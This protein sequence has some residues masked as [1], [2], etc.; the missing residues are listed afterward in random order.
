MKKKYIYMYLT[1]FLY[2][3]VVDTRDGWM[4][5]IE[6]SE[7]C[8]LKEI[9]VFISQITSKRGAFDLNPE[10]YI[11]IECSKQFKWNLYFCVSGQ[12][13]QFWTVLKLL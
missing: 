12:S 5:M 8:I 10:R 2:I 3:L 13:Q 4:L 1:Y 11:Y 7:F 6:N 9:N